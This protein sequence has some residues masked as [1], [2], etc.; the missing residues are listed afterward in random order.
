M[1]NHQGGMPGDLERGKREVL[2]L[3][4]SCGVVV[5]LLTLQAWRVTGHFPGWL[6]PG[7]LLAV[8]PLGLLTYRRRRWAR[9]LLVVLA[10]FTAAAVALGALQGFYYAPVMTA[11]LLIVAAL[12]AGVAW[13]LQTSRHVKAFLGAQRGE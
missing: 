9:T 4:V 13:R 8:I 6:F 5:M 12:L 11:V 3:A 7:I 2:M 10:A 1:R